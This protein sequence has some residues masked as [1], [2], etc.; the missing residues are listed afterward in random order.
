[1]ATG[2]ILQN[3]ACCLV[4][5]KS[6]YC[7]S[8]FYPNLSINRLLDD[9]DYQ[10]PQ[11][12]A[13]DYSN[14][15]PVNL[16]MYYLINRSTQI[17]NLIIK[18]GFDIHQRKEGL[19]RYFVKTGYVDDLEYLIELGADI[20]ANDGLALKKAVVRG[21]VSMTKMLINHAVDVSVIDDSYL[22]LIHTNRKE[23]IKCLCDTGLVI[24]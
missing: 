3:M 5:N 22:E 4:Y 23:I 1:M 6:K 18:S 7:F 20:N 12:Y 2:N 21:D 13:I 8:Q 15:D 16:F 11:A 24:D 19:L 10:F 14:N 17:I 9:W